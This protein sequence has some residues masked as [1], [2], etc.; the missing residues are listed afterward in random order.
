MSSDTLFR[1]RE[2][3]GMQFRGRKR[4]KTG[5]TGFVLSLIA[6]VIVIVL[7]IVSAAAKGEA[8]TVVGA[9]GLLA[10]VLSGVALSFSVKGLKEQDVYTKLPFAGLLLSGALFV[11]LFCLYVLGIQ[12]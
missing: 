6:A 10:M 12:F 2:R 11:F 3:G 5:I 4:S 1:K 8:G 7:C 9:F